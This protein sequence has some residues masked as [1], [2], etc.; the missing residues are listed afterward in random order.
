[1]SNEILID[2]YNKK[3]KGAVNLELE[4]IF[5]ALGKDFEKFVVEV[6]KIEGV[7]SLT[8]KQLIGKL[9]YLGYKGI[10]KTEKKPE[11]KKG[12]DPTKKDLLLAICGALDCKID[13][14]ATLNNVKKSEL[15]FLLVE[16]NFLKADIA[17]MH[18]ELDKW[19][20]INDDED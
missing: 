12:S 9:A 18:E 13:S 2:A 5:I 16:I 11:V 10:V 14:I 1:M 15:S 8:R 20:G 19:T 3:N 4:K 6:G 7:G 17:D